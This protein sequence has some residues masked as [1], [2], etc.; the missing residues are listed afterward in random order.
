MLQRNF[1]RLLTLFLPMRWKYVRKNGIP[2]F[3]SAFPQ[4]RRM[5]PAFNR[6]HSEPILLWMDHL[7]LWMDHQLFSASFSLAESSSAW[8]AARIVS[9]VCVQLAPLL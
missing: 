2:F 9:R 7:L 8:T 3:Y 5:S 6:T 1:A 4:K